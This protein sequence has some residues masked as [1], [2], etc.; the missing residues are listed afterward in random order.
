MWYYADGSER[1]GPLERSD[2]ERLIADGTITEDTL[3]WREGLD[4]WEAADAHFQMT[5][6]APAA[7][8]PM[9]D[10]PM[11]DAPKSEASEPA[12]S[13]DIGPDGLYIHAP[14]RTF[15]EAI[16][17][18]MSKFVTF[19][20]RASRSEYWFFMLLT[21]IVSIVTS[22]LDVV[23]FPNLLDISPLNSIS[24]LILFLPT[25]SASVRR[26]H[27]TDRSGWWIGG[28]Y[29][30]LLAVVVAAIAIF[31]DA[32]G[33]EDSIQ[34]AILLGICGLAFFIYAIVVLIFTIQRGTPG[35]NRFG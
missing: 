10:A 5:P 18:C 28:A 21:L 32:P 34:Y 22:S 29:L 15:S 19:K 26:L 33:E 7:P 6:E 14:S 2:I 24:A 30:F 16:S 1:Q 9:P 11:P 25:L 3:V 17:T 20:G 23:L 31:S 8:P 12:Q 27:D 13:A 4:G 35:P